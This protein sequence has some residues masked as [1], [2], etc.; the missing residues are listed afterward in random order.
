MD[1]LRACDEPQRLET[2]LAHLAHIHGR[3]AC[4]GFAV[5]YGAAALA[6]EGDPLEHGSV[7]PR[8][9]GRSPTQRGKP[10]LP[11]LGGGLVA[12]PKCLGDP[13]ESEVP[14]RALALR[15]ATQT[16]ER[17]SLWLVQVPQ[18]PA[19]LSGPHERER[20][21]AQSSDTGRPTVPDARDSSLSSTRA[22]RR[23][24]GGPSSISRGRRVARYPSPSSS[25]R[26]TLRGIR[27]AARG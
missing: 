9:E 3:G 21:R 26:R 4:C 10:S 17:R 1:E 18:P 23:P 5:N 14:P 27:R 15:R 20:G 8:G 24:P 25:M 12:A 6:P 2:A 11:R 16:P 22:A 7:L 13:V 19:P